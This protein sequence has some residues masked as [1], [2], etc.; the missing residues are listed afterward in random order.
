MA[1]ILPTHVYAFTRI[2]RAEDARTRGLKIAHM[3]M[4]N[5]NRRWDVDQGGL[6][7]VHETLYVQA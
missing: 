1:G 7:G 6:R 3:Q 5:T 4:M 2:M